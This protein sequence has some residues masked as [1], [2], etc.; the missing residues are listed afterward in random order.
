MWT[1]EELKSNAKMILKRTYWMGF[2]ACLIFGFLGNGSSIGNTLSGRGNQRKELQEIL[3]TGMI[4]SEML[5]LLTGI[6]GIVAIFSI[7]YSIFIAY[8]IMVGKNRFFMASRE[9]DP[10]LRNIFYAFTSGSYFN[11]VKSTFLVDLYTALWSLLFV[12]PGIIKH[13]EYFFVP[14][15]LSENPQIESRRAFELSREM[16]NGRKWDIFVMELSFLGWYLLGTLC[17]GIGILFVSPYY[18]A[19]LAE[20][21]AASRASILQRGFV[22]SM[23]LPGYVNDYFRRGNNY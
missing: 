17:C 22:S 6:L 7:F 12:I 20:L 5:S 15:I 18:Q 9:E 19:T 21:Y 14:Y 11:I 1:R 8:P 13:Y 2:V 10:E 3:S 23:E 4:S 16:S